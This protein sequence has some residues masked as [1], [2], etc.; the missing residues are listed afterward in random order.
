MDRMAVGDDADRRGGRVLGCG[1]NVSSRVVSSVLH[2]CSG[3]IILKVW[4]TGCTL[5]DELLTMI[6]FI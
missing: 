6:T 5:A 1:I 2:G 3:Q 4:I